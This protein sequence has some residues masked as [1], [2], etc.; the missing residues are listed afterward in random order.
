MVRGK[1]WNYLV[2]FIIDILNN[3]VPTPAPRLVPVLARAA[4]ILFVTISNIHNKV[5][6][7]QESQQCVKLNWIVLY[8]TYI[9]Y[10]R[11]DNTN[12]FY[13]ADTRHYTLLPGDGG[14][15]GQQAPVLLRPL[16]GVAA[17]PGGGGGGGEG[18]HGPAPPVPRPRQQRQPALHQPPHVAAARTGT[19]PGAWNMQPVVLMVLMVSWAVWALCI[20]SIPGMSP[21]LSIHDVMSL[22]SCRVLPGS[23]LSSYTGSTLLMLQLPSW[24]RSSSLLLWFVFNCYSRGAGRVSSISSVLGNIYKSGYLLL[25]DSEPWLRYKYL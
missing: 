16:L 4:V 7:Q 17:L 9:L 5:S 20:T 1:V 18:D 24:W 12:T 8:P 21:C 19:P 23:W 10:R 15:V 13:D 6:S 22:G 25:R 2:I 14:E 11:A 3:P